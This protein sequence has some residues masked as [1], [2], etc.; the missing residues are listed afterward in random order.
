MEAR[1]VAVDCKDVSPQVKFGASRDKLAQVGSLQWAGVKSILAAFEKADLP[2][3]TIA[4]D[5]AKGFVEKS[6]K[7]F[8]AALAELD[9]AENELQSLAAQ[10]KLGAL[11]KSA[12]AGIFGIVAEIASANLPVLWQWVLKHPPILDAIITATSNL[13]KEDAESL[14]AADFM[15]VAR[16]AWD[17][18]LTDG[19]FAEVG[20][21]FVGL[22]GMKAVPS[23]SPSSNANI[24]SAQAA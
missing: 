5:G 16:T 2:I 23:N 3:P 20:G 17:R 8:Q 12:T 9:A 1:Q 21:F 18:I 19:F 14:S 22:L 11:N 15:R 10:A 13:T 24:P 6:Q 7:E 4:A